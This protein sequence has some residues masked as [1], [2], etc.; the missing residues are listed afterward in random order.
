M[1]EVEKSRL[2]QLA[3]EINAEHRAFAGTFRKA[4]EHGIRC[5]ELLA[6]AKGQCKHGAWLPWLNENFE[7]SVR[8]AQ[9]Y[10]RLYDNRVEVRAKAQ[11]V[12]HLSMSGALKELAA[13]VSNIPARERVILERAREMAD[14]RH[15]LSSLTPNM[16][17]LEQDPEEVRRGFVAETAYRAL[18]CSALDYRHARGPLDEALEYDPSAITPELLAEVV[19]EMERAT[20]A[21]RW[22][23]EQSEWMEAQVRACDWPPGQG[24]PK[25]ALDEE[26]KHMLLPE[27]YV[28]DDE[29]VRWWNYGEAEYPGDDDGEG[30][31]SPRASANALSGTPV[32]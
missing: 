11:D 16:E 26:R 7:G 6:E 12:A 5:G 15:H 17:A 27:L 18:V 20:D 24:M 13:P 8:T 22:W 2:E 31:P 9:G 14:A 19:A 32:V 29:Y 28:D 4:V 10:M 3:N 25:A 21:I 30:L 23:V 1:S